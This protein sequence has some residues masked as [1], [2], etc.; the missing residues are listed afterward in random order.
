MAGVGSRV[1]PERDVLRGEALRVA[2]AARGANGTD[3]QKETKRRKDREI[4]WPAPNKM[5]RAWARMVKPTGL[6]GIHSR[7]PM[8]AQGAR[9]SRCWPCFPGGRAVVDHVGGFRVV[10]ALTDPVGQRRVI[11]GQHPHVHIVRAAR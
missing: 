6:A 3:S 1:A 2:A 11:V 7:G 10:Q 9:R 5:F 4:A 8:A